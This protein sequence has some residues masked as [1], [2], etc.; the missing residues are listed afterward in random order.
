M[1]HGDHIV[2]SYDADL[3]RLKQL[4]GEMGAQ[5]QTQLEAALKCVHSLSKEDAEAVI[6]ND[7]TIDR[8]EREID[9]FSVKILAL[10]HPVARDLRAVV[11]ALKISSDLERIADYA[12]NMA[13]RSKQIDIP[14][15]KSSLTLT[16]KMVEACQ[17]MLAGV[18]DA[19]QGDDADKAVQVWHEDAAIDAMYTSLLRELLT[20]M[21]ENPKNIGSCTQLLFIA[22]NIERVGDH[23]T[24]ICE[25]IYYQVRGEPFLERKS[26]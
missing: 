12:A 26:K 23:V 9:N 24:N 15:P 14:L 20:Y 4:I 22:K 10:R 25:M 5:V 16:D 19:Y 6:Q 8:K 11:S 18:L 21:M 1:T 2:K 7:P 3:I 17:A 13:K